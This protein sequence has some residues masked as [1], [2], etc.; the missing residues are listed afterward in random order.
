MNLTTL[1][2]VKQFARITGSGQDAL[3]TALIPLV[4]DQ[5][6]KLLG[7]DLE[8][9]TYRAWVDGSGAEVLRLDNW[10]V[11]RVYYVAVSAVDVADVWNSSSSVAR[12]EVSTDATG[13]TLTEHSTAGAETITAKTYASAATL[14]L[15]E[16]AIEGA[17]G[18]NVEVESGYTAYPSLQIR[19]LEGQYA[20]TPDRADL[21]VPDDSVGV[22]LVDVDMIQRRDGTVFPDCRAGVYVHYKAGYTLPTNDSAGT[23]PGGLLLLVNQM[24]NDAVRSNTV[25]AGLKSESLGDYSY[26]VGEVV[27]LVEARRKDLLAYGRVSL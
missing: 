21:W 13:I 15:L 26:S 8:E 1:N 17:A 20:Y 5:V 25:N 4:S 11:T 2:R 6:A 7:A 16:A 3:I 23:L 10:P 14:T 18:W 27:S 19:P 9:T 12:A 22:K 24:V